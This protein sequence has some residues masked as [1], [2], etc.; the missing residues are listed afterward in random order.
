MSREALDV[1][2]A[3]FLT[4][5]IQQDVRLSRVTARR[6]LPAPRARWLLSAFALTL[7]LG[8]CTSWT[9]ST[10]P[11]PT[12]AARS[13][14]PSVPPSATIHP[15]DAACIP[16][17]SQT[18]GSKDLFSGTCYGWR[19]AP[20]DVLV[21]LGL[22]DLKAHLDC[23]PQLWGNAIDASPGPPPASHH[24]DLDI[25]FAALPNWSKLEQV[26]KWACGSHG[27]S[28]SL[29][30]TL[31]G[32]SVSVDRWL[33]GTPAIETEAVN[34]SVTGCEVRSEP[35]ICIDYAPEDDLHAYS[36]AQVVVL[37]DQSFDPNAVVLRFWSDEVDL[38]TLRELAGEVIPY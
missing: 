26:A 32:G 9:P 31:D 23:D 20:H 11:T 34:G 3:E 15:G 33:Q 21:A 18:P 29:T 38:A 4:S 25:V 17:D 10:G 28:E 30:L 1:E 24:T 8:G 7:A 22:H 13:I 27:V 5:P 12:A 2:T 6:I 19:L 14:E 16:A 37:E 36:A 35:A